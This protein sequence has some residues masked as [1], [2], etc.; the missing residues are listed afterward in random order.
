MADPEGT[1]RLLDRE[2]LSATL[3]IF[4]FELDGG[5]P[6]F[7]PGQFLTL[8]LPREPGAPRRVWRA[9]SIASPPEERAFVELYVRWAVA[10]RTGAFTTRLGLLQPGDPIH[11]RPPR[12]R[13][14]IEHLRPDGTPELR[15]LVLL[16]GGTGLA[17]FVSY[18]LHLRARGSTREVVVCH[19]ASHAD[20][21]AYRGLFERLSAEGVLRLAYLPTV[22][23]PFDERSRHWHGQVGRVERLLERAPDGGPSAL[24]RRLG[25]PLSPATS[26]VHVCGFRGTVTAALERLLPLGFHDERHP[27]PDGGFDLKWESYG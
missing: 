13:F 7:E 16:A 23:R 9:Y 11:W 1:G 25:A 5:V 18:A 2:L 15:R 6:P 4:R 14:T 10:P 20:E 21:L 3:G 22:S 24:E 27:H 17:P 12:G 26:F 8:G 19:G